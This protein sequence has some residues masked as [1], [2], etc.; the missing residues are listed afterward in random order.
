MAGALPRPD[1]DAVGGQQLLELSNVARHGG[2]VAFELLQVAP[3][4]GAARDTIGDIAFE[5]LGGA[6]G[7]TF[8]ERI[9]SYLADLSCWSSSS[10]LGRGAGR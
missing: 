6:V 5:V 10:R 8:G 1:L 4:L 7:A 2:F 3:T 9:A